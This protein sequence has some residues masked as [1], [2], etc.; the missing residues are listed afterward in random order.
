MN[1]AVI[2]QHVSNK[3]VVSQSERDFIHD[4]FE[5]LDITSAS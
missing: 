5:P 3:V 1:I 4:L 2:K